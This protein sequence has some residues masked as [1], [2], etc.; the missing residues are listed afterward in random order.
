MD[1][2]LLLL[3]TIATSLRIAVSPAHT[4]GPP[5]RVSLES[6]LPHHDLQCSFS[7]LSSTIPISAPCSPSALL[8]LL[9]VVAAAATFGW[10]VLVTL[11]SRKEE[12]GGGAGKWV[13]LT[14]YH[15]FSVSSFFKKKRLC[16]AKGRG[17]EKKSFLFLLLFF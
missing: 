1:F 8:L 17:A 12:R 3:P 13:M 7:P 6:Y 16:R 11:F 9:S 5:K 10:A 15:N 14:F 4:H 2:L